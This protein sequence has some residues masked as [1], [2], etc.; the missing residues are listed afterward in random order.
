MLRK[1]KMLS[2]YFE[3]L[4]SLQNWMSVKQAS[5]KFLSLAVDSLFTQMNKSN[6]G[7]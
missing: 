4:K 3:Q 2:I 1:L 6:S 7:E 5:V